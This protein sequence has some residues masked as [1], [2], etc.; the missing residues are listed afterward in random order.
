MNSIVIKNLLR[1]LGLGLVQILILKSIDISWGNFNFIHL[2]IYPLVILL[3]P[4]KTP[5]VI[6]ILIA[7][8]LGLTIDVFYDSLGVHA[9][10]SVFMAFCRKIVL[11]FL[12]PYGGYKTDIIPSL[13]NMGITWFF[14][15][16]GILLF[17][18]LLFYFS[19]EAFSIVFIFQILMNTIFSFIFS[20]ILIFLHQFIF[21]TKI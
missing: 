20:I 10:A 18:H 4:L 1:F 12:E 16:S 11:R 7:F 14:I 5:R 21:N 2:F 9:S 3:L 19:M 8:F 13:K 17:L 6:V 15:Y